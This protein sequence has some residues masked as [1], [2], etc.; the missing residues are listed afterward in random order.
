MNDFK[1]GLNRLLP[2]VASSGVVLTTV[3]AVGATPKAMKLINQEREKKVNEEAYTKKDA[4]K[5]AWKCYIPAACV[6][7][8]TIVC[9]FGTSSINKK[10]QEALTSAYILL[11]E[12]YDKYKAKV[13]ELYGEDVHD[14]VIQAIAKE[15]CKD[16]YIHS[17]SMLKDIS[18]EFTDEF[19][20]EPVHTFYDRF[21]NRYFDSTISRVLQAEYHLNRNFCLSGGYIT[22]NEFYDFLGLEPTIPGDVIGWEYSSGISWID[23]D[24]SVTTIEDGSEEGCQIYIIDMVFS[25]EPFEE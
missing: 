10:N 9:I 14:N 13:K 2:V 6:G 11:S 23:F 17:D 19:E 22:L 15:D 8:A 24:H 1:K 4:I 16:V 5:T 21:S 20:P 25:P 7:V 12:S 18:S 3:L